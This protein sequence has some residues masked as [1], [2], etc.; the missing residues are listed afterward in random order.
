[1]WQR[2]QDVIKNVTRISRFD[3]EK[4]VTRKNRDKEKKKWQSK[5]PSCANL[6]KNQNQK[7]INDIK[8]K[9]WKPHCRFNP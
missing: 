2:F 8:L 4:N 6:I 7:T 3:K 1:M 9:H 5:K